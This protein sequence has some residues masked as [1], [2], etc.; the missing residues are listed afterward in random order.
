MKTQNI[1]LLILISMTLMLSCDDILEED[2]TNDLVQTISPIEG[3]IIEGNT[4]QFSWRALD[5][6]DDYRIQIIKSNQGYEIDSLVTT[7]TFT[8]IIDPGAYQWRVR[9]ENFAYKTAFTF[10]INFSAQ[11]SDDLSNQSVSLLT[12]TPDIY[13]NNANLTFTWAKL[14][15]ADT[16]NFDLV[17]KIGGEQTVFQ[18]TDITST[19]LNMDAAIFDEDAEY[20]WKV[21][22]VNLSSETEF[23]KQS[24]FIDRDAPNQPALTTPADEGITT[25]T[26]TFNWTNGSDNGNVK[27]EITNTIEIASD[28]D[29]N[30]VIHTASTLNNTIQYEFDEAGTYYWRIK[31][32]DDAGNQSDYSIVRSIEVE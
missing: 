16:Y 22:G 20:I 3:V 24:L 11:L 32:T 1:K 17:K 4:I 6:A 13:T 28:V 8:Y 18:Q 31:A 25:K 2:I 29:F 10:P 9:G 12:P 5:G 26:V 14:E 15:H 7:N 30:T 23:S 19:S 27:S 21:K